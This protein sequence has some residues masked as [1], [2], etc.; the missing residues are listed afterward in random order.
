M[1]T[2][3]SGSSTDAYHFKATMLP[4]PPAPYSGPL[5][6]RLVEQAVAEGVQKFVVGGVILG[7]DGGSVLMLKRHPSDFMPGIRELPSGGVD[8]GETLREGIIREVKEETGLD[9]ENVGYYLNYFDYR[10]RTGKLT[11]QF[12]FLLK[13]IPGTVTLNPQEHTEYCWFPINQKDD[14]DP[15]MQA[16][17]NLVNPKML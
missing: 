10:S 12:N 14:L 6:K 16:I 4:P 7:K 11:R 2:K 1:V 9:T 5:E 13:I 8:E 3:V 17:F 15:N